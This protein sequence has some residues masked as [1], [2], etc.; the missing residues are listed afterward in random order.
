M[1][2]FVKF[3][4]INCKMSYKIKI[5][6]YLKKNSECSIAFPIHMDPILPSCNC[7]CCSALQLQLI[8]FLNPRRVFPNLYLFKSD[9]IFFC[10][11]TLIQ[12]Q[13]VMWIPNW[14]VCLPS[15]PIYYFFATPLY[16]WFDFWVNLFNWGKILARAKKN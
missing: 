7:L 2:Y 9:I 8:S 13:I 4:Y 6:L 3:D 16:A 12:N 10:Q 15:Q 11:Q 1:I 5:I 14:N